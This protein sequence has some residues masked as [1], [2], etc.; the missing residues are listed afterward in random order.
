MP[1]IDETK[2]SEHCCPYNNFSSCFGARCMAWTWDGPS[3]D[4]CETDNLQETEE[5]PRP[6][7]VPA[8]PEGDGWEADG[9]SYKKGY[10]QSSK[11]KLPPAT[12]QRWI[13]RR[14]VSHG[15]CSRMIDNNCW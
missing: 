2:A 14:S 1:S 11:N 3:H 15:H 13:R 10:H 5:G 8:V 6:L 9:P 7:G 12:G 4:R